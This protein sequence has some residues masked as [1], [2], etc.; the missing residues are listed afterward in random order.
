[1]STYYTK[2]HLRVSRLRTN[3]E[4]F[5]TNN[6]RL[7]RRGSSGLMC[8][9]VILISLTIRR[10]VGSSTSYHKNS[11]MNDMTEFYFVCHF[12]CLLVISNVPTIHFCTALIPSLIVLEHSSDL[13]IVPTSMW[14][15]CPQYKMKSY[16][17]YSLYLDEPVNEIS[18]C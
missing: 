12:P 2:F 7:V 13:F 3:L 1:M 17:T 11:V 6:S 18:P 15:A 16:W 10:S 5:I 4:L 14:I 9:V 8:S